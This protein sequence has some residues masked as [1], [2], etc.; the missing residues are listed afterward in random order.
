M[1][2]KC[3]CCEQ[4]SKE[5]IVHV[6][7]SGEKARKVWIY[8]EDKMV[9]Y[10]S[11]LVLKLNEWWISKIRSPCYKSLLSFISMNVCRELW[12]WRNVG[13][14]KG[15][16]SIADLIIRNVEQAIGAVFNNSCWSL[17][18]ENK[19]KRLYQILAIGKH[20][21]ESCTMLFSLRRFAA[22]LGVC[23]NSSKKPCHPQDRTS[24][25]FPMSWFSLYGGKSENQHPW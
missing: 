3:N 18:C 24:P 9:I 12:K 1:A 8:F 7:V 23:A 14:Y 5:S 6:F 2:S 10:S 4:P 25:K 15:T 21:L 13:K 17:N 19:M 22:L 11:A 20:R 16:V